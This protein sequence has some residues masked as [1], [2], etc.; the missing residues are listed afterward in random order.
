MVSIK[1][2]LFAERLARLAP[3]EVT[4]CKLDCVPLR[5]GLE[6]A[7][8][9]ESAHVSVRLH[10]VCFIVDVPFLPHSCAFRVLVLPQVRCKHPLTCVVRSC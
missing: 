3:G 6:P 2:T 5:A 8:A 9:E 7:A 1:S 10:F 4:A